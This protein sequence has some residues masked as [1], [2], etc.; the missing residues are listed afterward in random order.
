VGQSVRFQAW[1]SAT[2]KERKAIDA[3]NSWSGR[4]SADGAFGLSVG[5]NGWKHW[6][7]AKGAS[8]IEGTVGPNRGVPPHALAPD[9][10][11]LYVSQQPVVVNN[12]FTLDLSVVDLS[13]P[14]ADAAPASRVQAHALADDYQAS[15]I[16][17]G[18]RKDTVILWGRTADGSRGGL[19]LWEL[20]AAPKRLAVGP[21]PTWVSTLALSP[22]GQTLAVA[23]NDGAVRLWD[24]NSL[25]ERTSDPGHRGAVQFLAFADN[26]RNLVSVSPVDQTARAW[27]HAAGKE[28]SRLNLNADVGGGLN[29]I[30][31]L[32]LHRAGDGAVVAWNHQ[33]VRRFDLLNNQQR[34]LSPVAAGGLQ[35]LAVSPDGSTLATITAGKLRFWDAST[36]A[37]RVTAAAANVMPIGNLVFSHDGRLLAFPGQVQEAGRYTQTVR[38]VDATTGADRFILPGQTNGVSSL[39]LSADGRYLAAATTQMVNRRFQQE[40]KVW[41]LTTGKE[42]PLLPA[43]EAGHAMLQFAPTGT[44][45][46]VWTGTRFEVWDVAAGQ[47]RFHIAIQVVPGKVGGIRT[48]A[49]SRDG[50]RLAYALNDGR[51]VL[52]DCSPGNVVQEWTLSAAPTTLALSADGR[53]VASA[54]PSG[55]IQVHRLPG[56]ATAP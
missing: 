10:R 28:R 23:S 42:R 21:L 16:L 19:R 40:W 44:H 41:D 46:A 9:G 7:L 26:D 45:L 13:P 54:A 4:L 43:P 48:V 24:A 33:G 32:N 34:D 20:G 11:T 51:L 36:G 14:S 30:F 29:P 17:P 35:F 25:V 53:Q 56:T 1:E 50:Q 31:G 39:T 15:F 8:E 37:A 22:D 52:H 27:D 49:F 55:L 3:P 47:S 5:Q 6:D 2:G 18:P 12:A 38:V